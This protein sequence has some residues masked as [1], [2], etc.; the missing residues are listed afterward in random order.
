MKT[1]L[2]L[3]LALGFSGNAFAQADTVA[4]LTLV[5]DWFGTGNSAVFGTGKHHPAPK[6]KEREVRFTH[7]D[8]T[9]KVD[10]QEGRN[11]S[12]TVSSKKPQRKVFR[13]SSC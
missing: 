13:R 1:L 5:G 7:P 11:F 8:M 10:R 12:G 2:S 9:F 6:G 4:T 3:V